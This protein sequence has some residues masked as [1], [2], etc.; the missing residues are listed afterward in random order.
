MHLDPQV[1]EEEKCCSNCCTAKQQKDDMSVQKKKA[2]F[3]YFM[4]T[5]MS[6]QAAGATTHKRVGTFQQFGASPALS[7]VGTVVVSVVRLKLFW[8]SS[9]G[10]WTSFL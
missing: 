8:T 9:R 5:S 4:F 7:N 3:R 10:D 1:K 6:N 2:L